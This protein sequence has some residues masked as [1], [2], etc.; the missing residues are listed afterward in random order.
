MLGN[1]FVFDDFE[2][3]IHKMVLRRAGT[4]VRADAL[5]LRLLEALVRKPG[6]LVTK[7]ELWIR[8]WEGRVVSDNAL[9]VA[10]ARLRKTLEPERGARKMLQT[11]HRHGYR[12]LRVVEV[13]ESH[14]QPPAAGGVVRDPSALVG[15]ERVLEQLAAALSEAH[16]GSGGLFVLTGE[17]GIGKTRVAEMT[18]REAI[19]AG[20]P[21]AWG[22]CRELGRTSPLWSFAGLLRNLIGQSPAARAVLHE[23]RFLALVPELLPL[24]PELANRANAPPPGAHAIERSL[25]P[26]SKHRLFDAVT[27]ALTLTAEYTPYVLIL[28]DLQLADTA[29]LELLLYLLPELSRTRI[30]FLATLGTERESATNLPLT[31]VL[32]DRN[33]TRIA[34][35][36]LSEADVASYVVALCGG[37]EP[38]LSRVVFDKS[39]GNPLFMTDLARQ[40]LYEHRELTALGISSVALQRVRRRI[41]KV[42]EATREVLTL[43]AM[44]GRS[45]SLSRLQVTSKRDA[46]TLMSHLDAAVASDL[47][48]PARGVPTEFAFTHEVVREAL[49]QTAVPTQWRSCPAR[50][51]N[52]LDNGRSSAKL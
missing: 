33:C 2:L 3:D 40:V 17:P 15:R 29:S 48:R 5:V 24:L 18:A 38:A 46:P 7:Q 23:S 16:S 14:P 26:D 35:Q 37:A 28:D 21:V 20:A 11:V 30:L 32:S 45:F 44:I 8:V 51:P 43:A 25:E 19:Q 10:I 49:Y 1:I 13:L 42:D 52:V 9:T 47:I 39:E 36:R 27:R 34:L 31:L 12:F 41:A 6:E 4:P 22:H 50:P